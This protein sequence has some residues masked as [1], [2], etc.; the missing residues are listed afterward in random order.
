MRLATEVDAEVVQIDDG[1]YGE[2]VN[3]QET[4]RRL[5]ETG[6]DWLVMLEDDAIP[7]Q[8]FHAVLDGCLDDSPGDIVSLY[9]GTGRWAGTVPSIHEPKVIAAVDQADANDS[10]WILADACWHAVG[11]AARECIAGQLLEHL[12]GDRSPTDEAIT[13]WLQATGRQIAYTH[14]S[15]VD[16]RDDERTVSQPEGFVP[17]HA[18]RF[19][20]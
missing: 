5:A 8:G 3:H 4:L 10:R 13:H 15:L 6:A 19:R 14:P 2:R 20:G 18:I 17:R 1:G 11:L 12:T 16:H 7:C 9:L